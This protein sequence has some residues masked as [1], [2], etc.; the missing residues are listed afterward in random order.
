MC[1]ELC[2]LA[3]SVISVCPCLTRRR[4]GYVYAVLTIDTEGHV[5]AMMQVMAPE[6]NRRVQRERMRRGLSRRQAAQLG[7]VSN[8]TWGNFEDGH[9]DLSAK[10]QLAVAAAF[11]WEAGWPY[12]SYDEPDEDVVN[13]LIE[14]VADLSKLVRQLSDRIEHLESELRR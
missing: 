6:L 7:G 11:D 10:I 14:R 1:Q 12:Q 9:I 2:W 3:Q 5:G 8:T 4:T 13:S